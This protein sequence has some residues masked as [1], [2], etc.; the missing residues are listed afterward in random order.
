M[1]FWAK[2]K[3]I[4][5]GLRCLHDMW[6]TKSRSF[7]L[8]T[9]IFVWTN[10]KWALGPLSCTQVSSNMAISTLF[11]IH[12]W[13]L[14][15]FFFQKKILW[16]SSSLLWCWGV[17]TYIFWIFLFSTMFL[18]CSSSSH[19]VPQVVPNSTTLFLISIAQNFALVA[20]PKG[21]KLQIAAPF[22]SSTLIT[23][24][25]MLKILAKY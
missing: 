7:F 4:W 15:V 6:E 19:M 25:G 9:Y 14:W 23:F 16:T 22:V 2:V 13:Q 17:L 20:R 3:N 1:F 5:L 10:K 8:K 18:M 21:R 11:F 24:S 12:I